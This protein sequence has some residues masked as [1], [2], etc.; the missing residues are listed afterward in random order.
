VTVETYTVMMT[1]NQPERALGPV[2]PGRPTHRGFTTEPTAMK[3]MVAEEFVGRPPGSAPTGPWTSAR[4]WIPEGGE[5]VALVLLEASRQHLHHASFAL[6][7]SS[8]SCLK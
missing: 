2:D 3:S 8:R 1:E 6:G 5:S 4:D 7:I